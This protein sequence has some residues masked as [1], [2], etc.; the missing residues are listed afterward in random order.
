MEGRGKKEVNWR[1]F[2]AKKEEI[3]ILVN[4]HDRRRQMEGQKTVWNR[5]RGERRRGGAKFPFSC[6]R[7]ES[8]KKSKRKKGKKSAKKGKK[9]N[10][11]LGVQ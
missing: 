4:G 8:N 7:R 10:N 1:I 6:G 5:A 3:H 9:K 2:S 11:N